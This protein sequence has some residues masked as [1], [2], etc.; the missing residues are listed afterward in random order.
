MRTLLP[1][2]LEWIAPIVGSLALIGCFLLGLHAPQQTL[3]SYLFAFLFFTGVS[4]GSLALAMVHP[5]AGNGEWGD[6]IR[7][8]LLAAAR[9][10][11]LMA[12]LLL[13]VLLGVHV[14][15]DW[16]SAVALAHDALLR[17]QSWY[18]DPTFFVIRSIVYFA[19][20]LLL[21]V[22]FTRAVHR[23]TPL[24]RIAAPG[25]I[26]YALTTLLAATDWASSLT[27]HWH[28]TTFGMMVAVGWML[29][30]AALATLCAVYAARGT[31]APAP[32]LRHDLG[33]L[34]LMLVLG[35]AY[36]AFMQ[37][38]TIWITDLPVETVWYIPRTLTSWHWLAWF[39]IAFH[40]VIPF[41]ALL[42]RRAKRNRAWLG[43][44]AAMLLIANLADAL[45]L[46]VPGFRP[47]GLS[48][49]L[50]DLLAP[51]GIGALWWS[52]FAGQWRLMRSLRA[53]DPTAQPG[54]AP[55]RPLVTECAYD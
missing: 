16:T 46:V 39:L 34:L 22:L 47:R 32:K 53:Q 51:L 40:F 27:P 7:P 9:V 6:F 52:V 2:R 48:L 24:A 31:D 37:Y 4:L 55:R 8:Q 18:L 19:L 12:I 33:N 41:C 26:V 42:S 30:A 20:W 10:L 54:G 13:P 21:L 43:A 11:P 35:F 49:R 44:I 29:A 17:K 23:N 5:L 25:L 28:S 3:L 1:Q 15:Y 38:L 36:L 45:W 14:L 50:T